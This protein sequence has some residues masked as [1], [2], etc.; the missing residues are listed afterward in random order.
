MALKKMVS[1]A[2]LLFVLAAI[3]AISW[4]DVRHRRAVRAA[5]SS[6]PAAPA[7]GAGGEGP[8]ETLAPTF[9]PRGSAHAPPKPA[10]SVD[11]QARKIVVTY[12]VTNTRC[13]SCYKIETLTE[14]AVV[15]TFGGPLKEGRIEWRVVNTDEPQNAHFLKD[16]KLVTKSVIVSEVVGGREVRWKN[17]DKVW[18]LLDDPKTFETYIVREVK[19]YLGDA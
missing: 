15:N 5:E 13:F 7:M 9:S 10:A 17:C 16:Y 19:A 14:S 2:L 12:F 11:L 4:K 3:A 8:Q 18:D 6:S 1:A